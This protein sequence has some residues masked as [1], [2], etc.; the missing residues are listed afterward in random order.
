[1]ETVRD[2]QKDRIG[3]LKSKD[4]ESKPWE[5]DFM[6]NKYLVEDFYE[7]V[8]CKLWIIPFIHGYVS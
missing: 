8:E 4:A 6:W 7:L 3:S 1:M 5:T 2:E